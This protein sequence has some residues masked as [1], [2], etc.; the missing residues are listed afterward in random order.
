MASEMDLPEGMQKSLLEA[1]AH[2]PKR[3]WIVDNSGSMATADGKRYVS[4]G[5]RE[6]L[7]SCTRWKELTQTLDFIGDCAI[8]LEA[9][10][11]FRLLNRPPGHPLQILTLGNGTSDRQK[12]THKQQLRDLCE[13]SPTGRTPIC[14]HI[15][16][17]VASIRAQASELRRNNQR[18]VVAIATDG[19]STDGDV[20]AALRPLEDLPVWVVI[21]LCTDDDEVVEYWNNIDSELELDMDVL[22]DLAGEAAEVNAVNPWIAYGLPLHRLR[23]WGSPCKL[24]DM[25]DE[26]AFTADQTQEMMS[27][28]L[29]Q[30]VV[31]DLPPPSLDFAGF[32]AAVQTVQDRE[33]TGKVW[34]PLTQQKEFWFSPNK[35]AGFSGARDPAQ[36]LASAP[37]AAPPMA[38]A[39]SVPVK[40]SC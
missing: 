17:V 29:G 1:T 37:P 9:T 23:E 15:R 35:V 16:A 8:G 21:K 36:C 30:R 22:D 24:L 20:A 39:V 34:N 13:T 31:S 19:C 3:Y 2:F 14:A 33:R 26:V 28:I 18:A 27:F 12:A 38:I 25:L 40:V 10:T 4:N 32:V 7:V 6:G 5:S 11:E